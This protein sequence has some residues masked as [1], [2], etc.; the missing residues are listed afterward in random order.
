M[1]DLEI[2]VRD[3]EPEA[4][5]RWLEQQLDTLDVATSA[6]T[7]AGV[8]KGHGRYREATLKVSVYPAAFGRRYSSVLLEGETLPWNTDLD[9]ARSAWRALAT[10]V[11][12]SPGDWQEGDPVEAEKWW[13]IDERGE[14]LVVWN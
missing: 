9:C 11:R 2:Y 12:C 3:L 8:L 5:I 13:R 6:D 7:P 10:E 14:Q 4:L 1:Q